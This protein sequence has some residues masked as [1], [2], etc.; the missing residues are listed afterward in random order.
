MPKKTS[1]PTR[2]RHLL[3][4][5]KPWLWGSMPTMT[6][7]TRHRASPSTMASAPGGTMNEHFV[8]SL[9]PISRSP[10]AIDSARWLS[11]R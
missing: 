5:R 8:P 3:T 9:T 6:A 1:G 7:P 4:L 11:S 10:T 2:A